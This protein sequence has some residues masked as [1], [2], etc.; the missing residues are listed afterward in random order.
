[1]FLQYWFDLVVEPVL[2]GLGCFYRVGGKGEGESLFIDNLS[3]SLQVTGDSASDLLLHLLGLG[4]EQG[5]VG[6]F[7]DAARTD[8]LIH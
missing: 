4:V 7:N 5:V 6:L 3:L 8:G 2:S 1:M